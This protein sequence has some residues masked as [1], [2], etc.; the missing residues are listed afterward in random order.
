[1]MKR[2]SLSLLV[3]LAV[4]GAASTGAYAAEKKPDA[5]L[6][7]KGGSVAAGIGFSWAS[8]TLTYQGKKHE[9]TVDGLSVGDVGVS[10]VSASG[11]VYGL[12]KLSDFDGNYSAVAAGATVGG[13]GSASTM[14]NQNGVT[15]DLL[16]T[17]QGLKFTF[18]ASGVSMKIKK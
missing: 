6:E 3:V 18:A 1:M 11:K 10:K 7:L 2:K 5:T 17:S 14:R 8:G 13:G 16:S 4:I 12:K 9:V 15:I